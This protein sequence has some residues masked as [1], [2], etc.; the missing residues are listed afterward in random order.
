MAVLRDA[1]D[2]Y[3]PV[4]VRVHHAPMDVQEDAMLPAIQDAMVRPMRGGKCH[5]N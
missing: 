1:Q 5:Q 4:P 2:V 3:P